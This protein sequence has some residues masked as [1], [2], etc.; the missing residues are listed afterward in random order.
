MSE[1]YRI[2]LSISD[3]EE[4]ILKEA[5]KPYSISEFFKMALE[6]H[7]EKEEKDGKKKYSD[8]D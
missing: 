8:I 1:K 6:N 4:E 2:D 3:K 7:F 5:V